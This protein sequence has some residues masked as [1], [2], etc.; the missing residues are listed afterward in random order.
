MSVEYSKHLED[1]RNKAAAVPYSCGDQQKSSGHDQHKTRHFQRE[2]GHCKIDGRGEG[3]SHVKK[4]DCSRVDSN[5]GKEGSHVAL[6]NSNDNDDSLGIKDVT[7]RKDGDGSSPMEADSH[8]NTCAHNE[9]EG[10]ADPGAHLEAGGQTE[11]GSHSEVVFGK[12]RKRLLS[13]EAAT[14]IASKKAVCCE[15]STPTV[16]ISK[17]LQSSSIA[18]CATSATFKCRESLHKKQPAQQYTWKNQK[19][20]IAH[21]SAV[22]IQAIREL[23]PC[24]RD[25][26]VLNGDHMDQHH[27]TNQLDIVSSIIKDMSNKS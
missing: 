8:L 9:V 7:H 20:R 16:N 3:D 14:M 25:Q 6:G 19:R 12:K 4:G 13:G 5:H 1:P 17:T 26:S 18:S 11:A 23:A 22:E 2:G 10:H 15:G 27:N 24:F 21:A